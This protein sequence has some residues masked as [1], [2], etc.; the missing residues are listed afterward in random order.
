VLSR[1]H[2]RYGLATVRIIN[3]G[4]GLFAPK[5]LIKRLDPAHEPSAAA[6]YAFRLFGIRTILLGLDLLVRPNAEVQRAMRQGVLIHLSDFLTIVL[7]GAQRKVPPRSAALITFISA[8]NVAM[9][10][11]GIEGKS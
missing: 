6:I 7:L 3:G 2:A 10:V 8:T 5:V 11:A 9:A 4:L 1:R